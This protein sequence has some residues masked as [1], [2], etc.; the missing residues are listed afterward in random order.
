MDQT[1]CH[2]H[3]EIEN[4]A[5]NVKWLLLA[6]DRYWQFDIATSIDFFLL[7]KTL[8]NTEKQKKQWAQ[9]LN[10]NK[11]I[12]NNNNNTDKQFCK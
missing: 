7:W 11:N 10:K 3:Y 1:S 8:K 9:T 6:L 5:T 2:N 4:W 12:Y